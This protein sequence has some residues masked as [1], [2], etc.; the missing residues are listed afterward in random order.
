MNLVDDFVPLLILTFILVEQEFDFW[1][2]SFLVVVTLD[3]GRVS[4]DEAWLVEGELGLL[5][6]HGLFEILLFIN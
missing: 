1:Q 6:V 5:G 3:A 4:A 2:G